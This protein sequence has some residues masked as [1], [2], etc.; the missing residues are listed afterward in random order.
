MTDSTINIAIAGAGGRMG[1][2]LIRAIQQTP[3]VRLN[4][5]LERTGSSLTGTDAGELAGIGRLGIEINDD[6][7]A[8]THDFDLLIDFTRP[9][10]TL[11]HLE[12]CHQHRKNMVIGTTGLDEA[13]KAAIDTAAMDIPIVFSANFSPGINLIL[14]LLEKTT[15]VIGD[16]TDIEIM[17]AHH[18]HKTD[19]PSGTALAMG[20]VIARTLNR[21]LQECA[22]Y[23]RANYSKERSPDSIG[24]TS[25]RAGDIV[26][27][28]TVMFADTSE[29]IEITHKASSRA[30]FARGAVKA[31]IWL[32]GKQPGLFDMS[33]VLDLKNL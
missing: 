25:I 7:H 32:S 3:G 1:R 5:A 18:R 26:G 10:G 12:F 4:A 2:Q 31:A 27:E 15:K 24:F 17:E 16:S 11:K 8:V 23:T 9:E 21:D 19:A 28:H 22:V 14:H 30:I 33:D 13:G 29:R 20:N 6:L